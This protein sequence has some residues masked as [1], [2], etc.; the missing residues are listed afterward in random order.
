[1]KIKRT[2]LWL[3][4][5]AV[6]LLIFLSIYGAFIG[7]EKAAKFFHSI[8]AMIYWCV[9]TLLIIS[10]LIVFVKL[11]TRPSLL[12]IHL[13]CALVILGSLWASPKGHQLAAKLTGKEKVDEGYMIIFEGQKDNRIFAGDFK[14][15]VGTLDFEVGL[16]DFR[17]DYYDLN[18]KQTPKLYIQI[19][20]GTVYIIDAIT[21]NTFEFAKGTLTV[22]ETFDD[23]KLQMVDDKRVAT[24]GQNLN[25]NPAVEVRIDL[26]DG[27]TYTRYAFEKFPAMAHY[28]EKDGFELKYVS[29]TPQTPQ[30]VKDYYSDLVILE[31]DTQTTSKTIEVNHPLH[32]KGYHFYQDSYD[33]E[34]GQYTILAVTSDSGLYAVYAGYILLCIGI[35]WQLWIKETLNYLSKNKKAVA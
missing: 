21:D 22:M 29:Q 28:S 12:A 11:R 1:M 17:L 13:G 8:P 14:T 4:L 35:V 20:D 5:A 24:N 16:N 7:A 2:T 9:C 19:P 27:T 30:M 23:F 32:Y 15:Q 18:K 6:I 3:T 10:G 26:V 33:S 25:D 34:N 31:N